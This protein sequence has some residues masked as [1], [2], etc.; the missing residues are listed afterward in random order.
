[1]QRI[2]GSALKAYETDFFR[3][4]FEKIP[5]E[6]R[7]ALDAL[8]LVPEASNG[9][10]REASPFS[11]LQADPGRVSL[12][13]I[14]KEIAKVKRIAGVALPYGLFASVPSKILQKI[15]SESCNQTA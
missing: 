7:A 12:E 8:L 13:S 14:L 9:K 1:M 3:A 4:S 15:C 10:G 11:E 6:C 5:G 2:L